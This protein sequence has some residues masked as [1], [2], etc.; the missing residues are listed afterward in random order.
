MP[1]IVVAGGGPAGCRAAMLA[2]QAPDTKVI[3]LEQR[4]L[5]ALLAARDS[6][7]SYPMVLNKRSTG[8]FKRLNLELPSACVPYQGTIML[9]QNVMRTAGGAGCNQS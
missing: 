4:S 7:R 5:D 3:L 2:A 1:R 8:L 6:R 9:P